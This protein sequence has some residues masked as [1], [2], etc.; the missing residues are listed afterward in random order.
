MQ[1][2]VP[3]RRGTFEFGALPGRYIHARNLIFEV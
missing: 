1:Q 3:E 2:R